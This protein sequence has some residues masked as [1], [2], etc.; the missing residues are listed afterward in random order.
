M[1]SRRSVTAIAAT[2]ALHAALLVLFASNVLQ[3]KPSPPEL[4]PVTVQLIQ[5]ATMPAMPKPLPPPPKPLPPPPKPVMPP[6]PVVPTPAPVQTPAPAPKPAAPA[7]PTAQPAAPTPPAPSAPPAPVA[8]ATPPVTP[9]VT[10]APPAPASKTDVTI[11]ASYGASNEK[12]KYPMMSKRLGEQG[13]VMLRVLVKSD[14]SAGT[15]EVKISSNFPRLD[16]AAVDAVKNWHF[17]PATNDGKPTDE[18][19]QVPIPFKIQN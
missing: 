6:M 9:P 11:S 16:Q 12:P 7:A 14:G 8:P 2:L 10:H 17:I 1:I 5:P 15:V 3:Q 13:T 18:W 19:Y 4:P